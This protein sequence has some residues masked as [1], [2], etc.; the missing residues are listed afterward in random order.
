MVGGSGIAK[1]R[2]DE[3]FYVQELLKLPGGGFAKFWRSTKHLFSP[4][5]QRIRAKQIT[6]NLKHKISNLS[7]KILTFARIAAS[8]YKEPNKREA[9]I[10]DFHYVP[11]ESGDLHALYRNNQLNTNVLAFRGTSQ[12]KDLYPDFHIAKGT[13]PSSTRHQNA[14]ILYRNLKQKYPNA[15][16]HT[17]GHSLGGSQAMFVAQNNNIHSY[18]FNPGFVAYTNDE[19]DT[20][21]PNHHVTVVKGDPISN[22]ILEKKLADVQVLEPKS[23]LQGIKAGLEAHR[24]SNFL[25]E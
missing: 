20:D 9:F 6:E 1:G 21:Y 5:K 4:E 14:N 19:I 8:P 17:T 3:D 11:H 24:M 10:N 12:L 2:H 13:E 16:F 23:N 15:T 18:A 25:N 7:P 22:S